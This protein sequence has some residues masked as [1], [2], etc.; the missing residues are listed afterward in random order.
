[1]V[2]AWRWTR[3][4]RR[5]VWRRAAETVGSDLTSAYSLVLRN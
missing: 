2:V 1:M 5:G 4:A 3:G